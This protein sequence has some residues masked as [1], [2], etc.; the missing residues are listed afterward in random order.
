MP[1]TE[2]GW[3][4]TA[5]ELQEWTLVCNERLLADISGFGNQSAPTI[6]AGLLQ[7]VRAFAAGAPQS[8]DIAIMALKVNGKG[9]RA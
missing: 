2:W 7:K 1:L 5:D 9:A 3:A 8:D 4:I 6:S